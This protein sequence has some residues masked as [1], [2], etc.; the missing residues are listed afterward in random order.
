MTRTMIDEQTYVVKFDID[1]CYPSLEISFCRIETDNSQLFLTS[2]VCLTIIAV[3]QCRPSKHQWKQNI[4]I[5]ITI[6][7]LY[8]LNLSEQEI[9]GR[10][11][12]LQKNTNV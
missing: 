10:Y 7:Q 3:V 5:F 4:S 1:L 6:L 2:G 12:N 11:V 9:L 8:A